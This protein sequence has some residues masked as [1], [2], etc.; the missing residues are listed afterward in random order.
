MLNVLISE[1]L[2]IARTGLCQ[3]IR[4]ARVARQIGTSTTRPELDAALHEGAWD[5]L[6]FSLSSLP[7]DEFSY[8]RALRQKLPALGILVIGNQP[9]AQ[10][11]VRA[12][13]SGASGY[14]SRSATRAQLLAAISTVAR[15]K[16]YL[17]Q[18]MMEII[19]DNLDTDW[20]RP[21]H[22]ALSDRE[23]QT[24]CLIG[25]GKSLSEIA[26]MMDISAKTVSAYRARIVAKMHFRNSAEIIHYVV[27][28][29][30]LA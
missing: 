28:N 17:P 2:D 8:L 10:L 22:D 23:Y 1:S 5:I 9:E 18:D 20:E 14:L 29:G 21:R 26:Q 30:L 24:L 19:A 16:K 3:I 13:K 27:S 11:A 4:E 7:S 25:S 15:G 6:L 12:F